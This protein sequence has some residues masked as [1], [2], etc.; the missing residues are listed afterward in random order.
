LCLE[1]F[2]N[3]RKKNVPYD[4]MKSKVDTLK[5]RSWGVSNVPIWKDIHHT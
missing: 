1:V 4:V 5:R 2:E 3:F